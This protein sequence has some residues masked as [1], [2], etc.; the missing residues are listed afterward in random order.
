MALQGFDKNYYLNAKLAA[1]QAVYPEWVGKDADFLENTLLTGYG[2]TAEDHYNQ[3]GWAEALAPNAYFN[4]AEYVQAKAT[5]L[6]NAG[7][8]ISIAD[9]EAAFYAAWQGN[10]YEHYLQYGAAENINPSND[11]DNSGYLEAKL[12][13]L[14]AADPDAYGDW[15]VDD[16]AAAFAAAGLTPLGHYIAYGA[17]EGIVP[18]P[19]P[20]DEQVDPDIS[21]PGEIFVLTTGQDNIVGTT[22]DDTILGIHDYSGSDLIRTFT[23]GDQIDGGDGVDTLQID[24]Y[25]D[26][27][28]LAIATITNVENLVIKNAYDDFDTLNIANKAFDT[29]TVDYQNVRN[30][31]YLYIDNIKGT[32]DLVIENVSTDDYTFY[33]NYDEKYDSTAG[34]VSFSNTLRN[35]DTEPYD[36]YAYFESYNYFSQATEVNHTFTMDTLNGTDEGVWVYEYIDTTAKNAAIYSTINIIDADT[37]DYYAGFY[38]YVENEAVLAD[39][40]VCTVVVNIENSDGVDFTYDT[41]YSGVSSASDVI[42]YNVNGLAMTYDY[43]ELW[44][45]AFETINVNIDGETALYYLGDSNSQG[46]AAMNIVA[47]ADLT[48]YYTYVGDSES[49]DVAVTVSGSG[50]VDLGEAYLGDGDADDVVTVDAS[51]LTGDF[52]IYDSYGYAASITSGAGNDAIV[53]GGYATAVSTGAGDDIVDTNG[54][55]FGDAD[56]ETLDGGDGRD[57][58]VISDG[59][60]LDAETAAN[61]SNFEILDFSNGTGTYDMSVESSL[62]DASASGNIAAAVTLTEFGAA[63]ILTLTDFVDTDAITIELATDGAADALTLNLAALDDTAN[64]TADGETAAVIVAEEFETINLSSTATPETELTA[65]D[66][67]NAVDFDATAMKTLVITGDAQAAVTFTA[68]EALTLVNASGNTAGV[69]VDASSASAAAGISFRG[70]AADDVYVATD[71]GD[72]IQAGGGADDITLGAGNDVVRFTAATDSRLVLT[73][74]TSPPDGTAD[75][76]S[77]FDA[78]TG[79]NL[80]GIDL[81]ELS[82]LLGLATG[83][84]RSDVLQKGVIAGTSAADMQDFIGDGADFFDTGLLDRAVAFA[85]DGTDGYLFVDI[86]G[87]GDFDIDTDMA[88]QLIAVTTF[89]ITDVTFG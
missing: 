40:D 43:N 55:D 58:I 6:F 62:V 16:V 81:I 31:D 63:N 44:S 64:D 35:F 45:Y 47:N 23:L 21:V 76:M 84:A 73:D 87:N 39:A 41:Y 33:R 29:V 8:F 22:G 65:A 38:F 61:I 7:R 24:V 5:A 4:Q 71:N 42:T 78:I 69:S 27:L 32:T 88:I 79:F 48:V 57:T 30:Y 15:T 49:D 28:D 54:Y 19:V 70:T 66:Y 18:V 36:D 3:Y 17:D 12:A 68:A 34:A 26:E 60:L 37:P 77:G 2:L 80:G 50:N 14:Q 83:D 67:V 72:T 89:A 56:A 86:D 82:S 25:D 13:L 11:F 9:A 75:T 74:T 10:P 53:V 59:A 1:L 51:A 20:A 46:D 52:S 85:N